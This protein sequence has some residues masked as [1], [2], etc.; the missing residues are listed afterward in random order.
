MKRQNYLALLDLFLSHKNDY[1]QHAVTVQSWQKSGPMLRVRS[2]VK[3][4]TAWVAQSLS[5]RRTSVEARAGACLSSSGP[6]LARLSVSY[7]CA[8]VRALALLSNRVWSVIEFLNNWCRSSIDMIINLC[9]L[10]GVDALWVL[11]PRIGGHSS[12]FVI[13]GSIWRLFPKQ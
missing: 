6:L 8:R 11:C 3:K 4:R 7:Y 13:C 9:S 12:R 1:P 2:P 10:L 5:Y